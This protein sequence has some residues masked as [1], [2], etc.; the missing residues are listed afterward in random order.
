MPSLIGSPPKP[1][2]SASSAPVREDTPW[3]SAGKMSGNLFEDRNWLLPKNYLVTEKKEDTN[4]T[5]AWPRLK[6]EPKVGEQA[7]SPR[8]EKCGWGQDCLFCKAQ[9]K[10]EESEQQ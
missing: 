9:K 7:T 8:V 3:P 6:E 1:K 10:E 5:S 4:V 2:S